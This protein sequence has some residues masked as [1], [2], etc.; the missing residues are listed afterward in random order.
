MRDLKVPVDAVIEK[1]GVAEAVRIKHVA[2]LL[3]TYRC[4]IAWKH[5]LFNCSPDQPPVRASFTDGLEFLRQIRATDRVTHIAGGKPMIYYDEML[6]MWRAANEEGFPPH[7]S[8]TNASWCVSDG[9]TRRR[10]EELRDAGA[11]GVLI[12][13]LRSVPPCVR[14]ASVL[15][16]G[17]GDRPGSI[18]GKECHG[19]CTLR[20]R[21]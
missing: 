1:K 2:S 21:A 7:F 14:P 19:E 8:E 4:T 13:K 3:F 18:R 12:S 20:G 15:P 5:C 10:Y 9:L 6:R 11:K 17:A 16:K